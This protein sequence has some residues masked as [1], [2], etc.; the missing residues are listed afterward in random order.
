MAEPDAKNVIPLEYSPYVPPA[1]PRYKQ[2]IVSVLLG[3]AGLVMAVAA[4]LALEEFLACLVFWIPISLAPLFFAAL[5]V[6]DPRKVTWYWWEWSLFI[7]PCWCWL[8]LGS[9]YGAKSFSNVLLEPLLLQCLAVGAMLVLVLWRRRHAPAI[10][11][12][13]GFICGLSVLAAILWRFLP[14]LPE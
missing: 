13:L 6:F 2:I 3:S 14:V 11:L 8:D 12:S 5:I 10:G 4:C 7:Y 1:V 9:L